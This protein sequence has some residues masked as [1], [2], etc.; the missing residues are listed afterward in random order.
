M[1]N[2]VFMKYRALNILHPDLE[3][4]AIIFNPSGTTVTPNYIKKIHVVPH[5]EHAVPVTK[6]TYTV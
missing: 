2:F 5:R 1:L 6:T 4:K 3:L